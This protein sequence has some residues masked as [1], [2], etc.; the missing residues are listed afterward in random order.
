MSIEQLIGQ[1][2][3][4]VEGLKED[5]ARLDKRINGTFD[6]IGEHIKSSEYYRERIVAHDIKMK[7]LTWIFGILTVPVIILCI[8]I[9]L[10]K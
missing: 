2:Q 1:V 8:K 4:I 5:V 6:N 10:M 7:L 3:G 9:F